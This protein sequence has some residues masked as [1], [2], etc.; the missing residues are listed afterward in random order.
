MTDIAKPAPSCV[1]VIFGAA[2]DLT[3]RL[4]MP[5]V[6]N[7]RRGRLLPDDFSII[8]IARADQSDETFRRAFDA[9]MRDFAAGAENGAEWKWLR[10]R[11]SY[12]KG[13]FSEAATYR[14]LGERLAQTG[15]HNVLFYLATPPAVFAPVIAHL[16]EARLLQECADGWRRVIIEKP[17]GTDL[18]SARELNRK[19]LSVMSEQ[20]IFRID[21]Y[22]GKETVQNIMVFRFGNGIFEPLWNRNHIDHVQ[23]TVAE[24]VGVGTRGKFYDATG[25]LRDMVPNHLFQLLELTA[26]EP[27]TCFDADAVRTEK[28]KVLDAVHSFGARDAKRNVVRGQYTAGAVGGKAVQA[29]RQSPDVTPDSKTETYVALKLMMDNWRWAGVPFYLRTGKALGTRRSEIVIRFKQAPFA[30]FR[31]TPIERLTPNDLVLHIQPDEGVTLSIGAKKPGPK[32]M[33]GGVELRFDYKDYFEAAPSTG[34]ETLIYDCM[35][36]DTT[37]FK[38][39]EEIESG[40][41]IVQPLIDLWSDGKVDASP[42]AA[43]SQGPA[44]AD[45]L[46]ACDGRSWRALLRSETS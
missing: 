9:G 44:E 40:W 43:G 34:Y 25:A 5:A 2:G 31:D 1:L 10:G 46:L 20:Q 16:G 22:L 19:I 32:V 6:C 11:M 33:M 45:A 4:L 21:H 42:Y 37:L 39:A 8:G 26:M 17:F 18:R 3:R 29:Y 7:L 35:T 27:P 36:G 30:L 15:Q 24:T 28:S 13:D 23:I 12:L 38:R 14:A 41:R